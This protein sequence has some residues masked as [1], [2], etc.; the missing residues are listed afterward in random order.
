MTSGGQ[1]GRAASWTRHGAVR[2]APR[3]RARTESDACRAAVDEVADGEA[4]RRRLGNALLA[5]PITTRTWSIR[6]GATIASTAQ[7]S[8]GL[9]PIGRIAWAYRRQDARPFPAA[10]ISAVTVM[11]GG[12]RPRALLPKGASCKGAPSHD[13]AEAHHDRSCPHRRASDPGA[14][15]GRHRFAVPAR[16]SSATAPG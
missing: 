16:S 15:D 7:R 8:T 9:P 4:P 10:T 3:A 5:S 13:L 11:R 12:L 6:D 1:K 2:R 14:D